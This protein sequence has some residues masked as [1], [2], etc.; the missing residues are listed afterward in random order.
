MDENDPLFSGKFLHSPRERLITLLSILSNRSADGEESVL[1]EAD[2][3]F[4]EES[5][6]EEIFLLV[7]SNEKAL[8]GISGFSEHKLPFD[9]LP[10]GTIGERCD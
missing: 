10:D 3:S 9:G 4:L 1:S 8:R 6:G 2:G 7:D 5:I